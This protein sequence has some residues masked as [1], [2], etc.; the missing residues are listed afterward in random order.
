VTVNSPVLAVNSAIATFSGVV[1]CSAL[2]ANA[3]ISQAYSPGAG[4]L[5]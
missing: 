5:I 1:Q 4:N 2:M 3:V